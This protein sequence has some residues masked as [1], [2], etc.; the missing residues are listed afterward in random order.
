MPIIQ[1][2][3]STGEETYLHVGCV[4]EIKNFEA[5]RNMSDTLDYSDYQTVACVEA[6][7]YLGREGVDYDYVLGTNRQF[8]RKVEERFKWIDVSNHFAW[9]GCDILKAIVDQ[10]AFDEDENLSLDFSS[11]VGHQLG[12]QFRNAE[13]AAESHRQELIARNER[14]ANTPVVGKKMVVVSG[15][16]VSPGH[17]GTVAYVREDRV[18]LKG[19]NEWK[20]RNAQGVWIPAR[21]LKAR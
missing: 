8:E 5:I 10:D 18:L 6:L 4:I 14:I 19:D 11:W 7:V 12:L 3:Q 15:R 21:H 13:R 1:T 20:D 17:M 9:R 2:K 16:K